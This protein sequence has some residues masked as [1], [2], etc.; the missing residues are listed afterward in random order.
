MRRILIGLLA[1]SL[2]AGAAFAS[3][4]AVSSAQATTTS[5]PAATTLRAA[6][7]DA[8][9][10]TSGAT[11]D[12]TAIFYGRRADGALCAGFGQAVLCPPDGKTDLFTDGPIV[13]VAVS[14][15]LGW[16]KAGSLQLGSTERVIGFTQSGVASVIVTRPDGATVRVGVKDGA[17]ELSG[18]AASI[19]AVDL[20]GRAVGSAVRSAGR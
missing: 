1:M 15:L 8:A 12:G 4:R 17:F 11:T 18:G 16:S 6:Q 3:L 9:T 5:D 13:T 7:V 19:Q 10:I 2:A 20:A 14:K